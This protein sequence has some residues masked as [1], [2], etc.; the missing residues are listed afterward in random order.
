MKIVNRPIKVVFEPLAADIAYKNS[1]KMQIAIL[2]T[3]YDGKGK[4]SVKLDKN[5]AKKYEN[6]GQT[7][8][9][10]D[11]LNLLTTLAFNTENKDYES[12]EVEF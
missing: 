5:A 1:L 6:P 2:R 8:K 3:S 10:T 12:K 9:F 4:P 7:I 11:T